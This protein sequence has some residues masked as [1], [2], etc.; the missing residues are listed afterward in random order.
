[1]SVPSFR[2]SFAH[3]SPQSPLWRDRLT[4][5][6]E[7]TGDGIYGID[8]D[9]CCTFIN[10]AGA[11][12]LGRPAEAIFGQNMHQLIHQ[13][14]ADGCP[15]PEAHCPIFQAFRTGR[16]CRNDQEVFW[17]ADGTAFPVEY[18]SH[19]IVDQ[20]QVCGAVITF[21]DISSRRQAE[22]QLQR[23]KEELEVRVEERTRALSD[24][25]SQ[26]RELSAHAHAVRENERTRIAREIHDE[27]GSLLVALKL[28]VAW[29]GKRVTT[30]DALSGKCASM[31]RLIET[32]VDDVGRIIT[33]LRPSILDHQGLIPALEWHI[34]DF[35]AATELVCDVKF[36]IDDAE[37]EPAETLAIAAFRIFQEILSNVARHAQASHVRVRIVLRAR[38]LCIDVED[39]GIGASVEALRDAK[40]YG[41]MG[42]RERALHFG[43]TM[44]I[45][46]EPGRGTHVSIV[47][48][49]D[50]DTV[51]VDVDGGGRERS[52]SGQS[53]S[54]RA[55]FR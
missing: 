43:G 44:S 17:R 28:D 9:G 49:L 12:M 46:S 51:G 45:D 20:G 25:L 47:L 37:A 14:H 41:V 1:M 35:S 29:I 22:A 55:R 38:T 33:D 8:L 16:S 31:S 39:D 26:L 6:L 4:L 19:Q 15:Y 21:N 2:P 13:M 40:A 10:R 5:L 54:D 7:S 42:M 11:R 32:A 18:S 36:D 24:A 53:R 52:V 3:Q 23:V 50:G 27:L 34:Q 48:P 30:S